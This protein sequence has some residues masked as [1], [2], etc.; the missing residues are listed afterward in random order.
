[1]YKYP[2]NNN[3]NN[4]INQMHKHIQLLVYKLS[5]HFLDRIFSNLR[6]YLIFNSLQL[7][8]PYYWRYS[9]IFFINDK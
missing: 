4:N 8:Q 3:N 1:M 2:N 9:R 6:D 7:F 5:H